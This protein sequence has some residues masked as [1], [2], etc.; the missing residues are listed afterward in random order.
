[1]FSPIRFRVCAAVLIG[2]ALLLW[3]GVPTVAQ[4]PRV[5]HYQATLTDGAFPVDGPVDVGAAFYADSMDVGAAFYA[6]STGGTP[7]AGWSESYEDVPLPDG[8]LSLLLGRTTP[9]PDAV[10]ATPALYLQLSVNDTDFPRLR[11][12]STAFAL[13]ARTAEAVASGAIGP[14]ALADG[15]V[16]AAKLAPE[17]VEED[18]LAPAAVTTAA[19]ADAAV[20]AAKVGEEAITSVKLADDAVTSAKLGPGAVTESALVNGAVTTNKISNGSVTAD[21]VATGQLITSLNGLTDNV[22]LVGGDNVTVTPSEQGGTITIDVD[23]RGRFDTASD[24]PSS[25]RWKADVRP[26]ADALALV[27]QLQG[28]RYRWAESGTPDIGFIAEEVGAVVPEVVT[29]APNGTDAETVN[30]ARLVALL[31]EALKEQQAQMAADRADLRALE[32]RLEALEA[33]QPA[34]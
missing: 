1:V 11:V 27:Q 19:L 10:L 17:A 26:L 29:Y 6:D 31:V 20:T 16:T 23:G 25:R 7:L 18:G 33:S 3:G 9:I 24:Q 22:R 21:K 13:R 34:P 32:A 28:V 5:L 4:V 15:A 14:E 8:R 12:A 30:Y 2:S